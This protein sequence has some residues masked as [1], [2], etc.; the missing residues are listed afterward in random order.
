MKK[1]LLNC[2]EAKENLNFANTQILLDLLLYIWGQVYGL[3]DQ[4]EG[5]W[6]IDNAGIATVTS[7]Q[8]GISTQQNQ[9]ETLVWRR[10]SK[11]VGD[12]SLFK[13]K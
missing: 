11:L 4:E 5:H 1:Y 13:V 3:T 2:S 6:F 8:K 7:L 10:H 9:R 12:I